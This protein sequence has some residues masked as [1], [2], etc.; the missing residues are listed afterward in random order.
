MPLRPRVAAV[1]P[2]LA[3]RLAYVLE[4]GRTC[5]EVAPEMQ[6]EQYQQYRDRERSA[7]EEMQRVLGADRGAKALLDLYSRHKKPDPPPPPAP[8]S[9]SDASE[10]K[11]QK[12][13]AAS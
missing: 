12:P 11:E 5:A 3:S 1:R 7:K 6:G 4:V 9:E 13:V 10:A 8:E 2:Q